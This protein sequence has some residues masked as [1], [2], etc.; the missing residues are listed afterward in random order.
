MSRVSNCILNFII[1]L[2]FLDHKFPCRAKKKTTNYDMKEKEKNFYCLQYNKIIIMVRACVCVCALYVCEKLNIYINAKEKKIDTHPACNHCAKEYYR[3]KRQ[4][5][6]MKN[7]NA[8]TNNLAKSKP[9]AATIITNSIE[10]YIQKRS[11]K[12]SPSLLYAYGY[13]IVWRRRR[14]KM[15][16]QKSTLNGS[17]YYTH[18]QSFKS[19]MNGCY[20]LKR[21]KLAA[22]QASKKNRH[23]HT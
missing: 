6:T 7:V 15:Y 23:T 5:E 16:N 19:K 1:I 20:L 14:K 8:Q 12:I 2:K 17:H 11:K 3:S 21:S 10:L 4:I 18:S 13:D 9:A 22:K